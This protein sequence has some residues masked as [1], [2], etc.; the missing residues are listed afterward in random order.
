[1]TKQAINIPKLAERLLTKR[2]NTI[3]LLNTETPSQKP[4]KE[5]K[6]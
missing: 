2:Q 5:T 6:K 1:M 3:K 4:N